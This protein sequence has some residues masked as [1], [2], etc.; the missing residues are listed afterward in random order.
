MN[1]KPTNVN[2]DVQNT[3]SNMDESFYVCLVEENI[4]LNVNKFAQ[5]KQ[6]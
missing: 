4:S 6:S 3:L 2:P 1:H 5:V